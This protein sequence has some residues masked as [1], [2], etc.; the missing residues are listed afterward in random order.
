[1]KFN[2]KLW[3]VCV[4]KWHESTTKKKKNKWNS[5]EIYVKTHEKHTQ[6]T[7]K[8]KEKYCY[9]HYLSFKLFERN[10]SKT[11]YFSFCFLF[12]YFILE[13]QKNVSY[14]YNF[15]QKNIFH[16]FIHKH[17]FNDKKPRATVFNVQM[18]KNVNNKFLIQ[19]S[20]IFSIHLSK[21]YAIILI[22]SYLFSIKNDKNS[23][24]LNIKVL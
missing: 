18:P 5:C 7:R 24:K 14:L 21:F 16:H 1:M 23:R 3:V 4:W 13:T 12:I 8:K 20:V 11:I 2:A 10:T 17:I 22:F 19:I 6:K 9:W 15:R